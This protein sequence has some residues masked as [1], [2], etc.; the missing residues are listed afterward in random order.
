MSQVGAIEFM[1]LHRW[2]VSLRQL[3][4]TI[5]GVCVFLLSDCSNCMSKQ[6]RDLETERHIAIGRLPAP[7]AHVDM[8]PC[9]FAPGSLRKF[10]FVNIEYII[11]I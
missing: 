11:A 7:R 8:K 2:W 5:D 3:I 6:A 10:W 4:A 1:F 9:L